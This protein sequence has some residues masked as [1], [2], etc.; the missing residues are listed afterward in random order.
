MSSSSS[1]DEQE[2]SE[3]EVAANSVHFRLLKLNGRSSEA[4]RQVNK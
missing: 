3:I 1:D 4:A 2:L